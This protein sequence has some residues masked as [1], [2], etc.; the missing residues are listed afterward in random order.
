MLYTILTTLFLTFFIS[1]V[2]YIFDFLKN[3]AIERLTSSIELDSADPLFHWVLDYLIEKGFFSRSFNN[4][5]CQL[6]RKGD[7]KNMFWNPSSKNVNMD[8]EKPDLRYTPSVGYQFF[9]YKTVQI[10]VYH[11]VDKVMMTGFDNQPTFPETLILS[12]FGKQNITLLKEICEE[13]LAKALEKDQGLTKIYAVARW[14]DYWEKVQTKLPRPVHT[15]ILDAQIAEEIISDIRSFR[16]SS[17]WYIERGVPYRR[18]YMLY[19]PPGTGKTSFVLA[20]ATELKL[21][22]CPVDLSAESLNDDTLM[23]IMNNTPMNSIILL[24]DVDGLFVERT[25]VDQNANKVSFAGLL[26]ALDGVRTQEGRIIFMTTNHIQKLDPALLR[27][28]RADVQVK[29]DFA[30][31]DQ[32]IRMFERF[33][34][35][36]EKGLVER[37]AAQVPEN[38]VSM[39]KLQGH[40]LRFKN[41]PEEA[42]D[43]AKFIAEQSEFFEE[44]TIKEWLCRLNLEELTM[45]FHK[46]KIRRVRDLKDFTE[47]DLEKCDVKKKGDL[48]RI[49]NMLK[50]ED[51][52]KK[53]FTILT[54]QALRGLLAL[55]VGNNKEIDSILNM[56]GEKKLSEFQLRDV[57]EKELNR[58][59]ID[60]IKEIINGEGKKKETLVKKQK[61]PKEEPINVL[62]KLKMERFLVKFEENDVLGKEEFYKLDDGSL[63][64]IGVD[65]IASRFALVD[66]IEKLKKESEE[67]EEIYFV[68]EFKKSQS[69]RY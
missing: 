37:F 18:G 55:Y 44:M 31:Q 38:K 15:V 19:G 5:T 57:F 10:T 43:K 39:A 46:Q 20:V 27:P 24:E 13:A 61:I 36:C 42:V 67:E 60:K 26:H 52:A 21:S 48:T 62:E 9:V 63:T 41:K 3:R 53:G 50:G 25:S 64:E 11:T 29:L 34:P 35:G 33:Y 66:E 51:N 49:L 6:D 68:R 1:A 58:K 54:S 2:Y 23:T 59:P 40:F 30:S 32:I 65:H 14:E 47:G 16:Q 8:N 45:G 69:I 17:S 56:I 12:C 7:S 4:L 28:G 22:I